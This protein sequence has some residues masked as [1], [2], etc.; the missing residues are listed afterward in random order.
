MTTVLVTQPVSALA[1]LAIASDAVL[2]VAFPTVPLASSGIPVEVADVPMGARLVVTLGGTPATALGD[3]VRHVHG[4]VSNGQ[5]VDSIAGRSITSVQHV[6]RGRQVHT[7]KLRD[8]PPMDQHWPA[9][10]CLTRSTD[11]VP[12]AMSPPGPKPAASA[13]WTPSPSA[14]HG[15]FRTKRSQNLDQRLLLG[16]EEGRA[17]SRH[18]GTL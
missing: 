18:V 12:L 2:P 3:H 14:T 6:D 9:T 17:T 1:S 5:V 4:V 13:L 15:T 16:G 7:Q 11:P 8:H 10:A